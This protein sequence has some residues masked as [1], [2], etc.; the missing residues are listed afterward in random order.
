MRKEGRQKGGTE[1]KERLRGEKEVPLQKII[2][3][4]K[5]EEKQQLLYNKNNNN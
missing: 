3:E 1:G 2:P 4:E 5:E